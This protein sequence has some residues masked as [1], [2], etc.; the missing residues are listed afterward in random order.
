MRANRLPTYTATYR[1][2][3][4]PYALSLVAGGA[5]RTQRATIHHTAGA[6]KV[7][8]VRAVEV[9]IESASAA[10]IATIDLVRITTAPATGNPAITP[11]PMNAA[12]VATEAVCL[13]LPTTQGTEGA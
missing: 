10:A 5:G 3:A 6:T 8:R 9:A 13:A 2:A 4:R 11:T 1:L 12:D 7:I